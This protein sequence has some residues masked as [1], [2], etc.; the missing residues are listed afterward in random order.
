MENKVQWVKVDINTEGQRLDNF[1]SSRLKGIP[2][3]RIYKMIRNGEVRINKARC[4]PG[5]RVAAGDIIRIPP[6]FFV[7][8]QP[9][10]ANK[11]IQV[12]LKN[13]LIYEDSD[14][15]VINKP[16]GLAVHGGSGLSTGLIEQLRLMRP[17]E[18]FLELVH[19]ID[20]ETSGCIL[21]A[22]CR[23]ALILLH[24]QFREKNKL[25]RK[26][27]LAFVAG[28]WPKN[29]MDVEAPLEKIN[30]GGERLIRVSAFGKAS[31][32]RIR[33]LERFDK[34]SLIE[35]EPITGRTHQIR[36]HTAY[37]KH[38]IL[39]DQKYQKDELYSWWK[40]TGVDG[41]CLHSRSISFQKVNGQQVTVVAPMPRNMS[42]FMKVH[43]LDPEG[44]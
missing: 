13:S 40:A 10:I 43:G 35:A 33:A 28:R 4:K 22:K 11:Q 18:K 23:S 24:E 1:L 34:W 44:Y 25:L 17:D 26:R 14:I 41:F 3:N 27:Y 6:L 42:F 20:R 29:I 30:R 16:S 39:G 32:T 12:K 7:A 5:L 21:L 31:H 2:K 15:L 37:Y 8:T 38:P 19:R 36:A 9:P